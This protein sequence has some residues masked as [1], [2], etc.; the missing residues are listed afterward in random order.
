MPLVLTHPSACL[1]GTFVVRPR[2]IYLTSL[3]ILS[4]IR[5]LSFRFR[6]SCHLDAPLQGD[7]SGMSAY[8]VLCWKTLSMATSYRSIDSRGPHNG[9]P[10]LLFTDLCLGHLALHSHLCRRSISPSVAENRLYLN[11]RISSWTFLS[12]DPLVAA[13]AL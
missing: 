2:F 4:I 5:P 7:R 12:A 13:T 10:S 1:K 6:Q 9:P 3:R 8:P 11:P